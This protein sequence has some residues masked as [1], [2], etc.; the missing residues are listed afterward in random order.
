[1][2]VLLDEYDTPIHA[3]HEYGYYEEIV[4]FMRNFLNRRTFASE[5]FSE[6]ELIYDLTIP[7]REVRSFYRQTIRL[8]IQKTV[9][10]QRLENIR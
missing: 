6:D 10:S 3:G 2:I 5:G 1:M 9:G 8:W 4:V 7:N